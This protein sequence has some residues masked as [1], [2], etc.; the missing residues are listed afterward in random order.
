MYIAIVSG[1]TFRDHFEGTHPIETL[2]MMR[3]MR[4]LRSPCGIRVP[5]WHCNPLSVWNGISPN[6][7]IVGKR[8]HDIL[9][10]RQWQTV[11]TSHRSNFQTVWTPRVRYGLW[12]YSWKMMCITPWQPCSTIKSKCTAP[13]SAIESKGLFRIQ[14]ARKPKSQDHILE[15]LSSG[16]QHQPTSINFAWYFWIKAWNFTTDTLTR[17]APCGTPRMVNVLTTDALRILLRRLLAVQLV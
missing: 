14:N 8:S 11:P 5:V 3:M 7:L 10:G 2:V 16:N 4:M 17:A 1:N 6:S 9:S 15:R 12:S 13:L